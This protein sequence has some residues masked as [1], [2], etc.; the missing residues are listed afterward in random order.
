M[1]RKGSMVFILTL[2]L[3]ICFP[4]AIPINAPTRPI[5]VKS[6]EEGFLDNGSNIATQSVGE[7]RYENIIV[8]NISL[9]GKY[10]GPIRMVD[11]ANVSGGIDYVI[12]GDDYITFNRSSHAI[13]INYTI[14]DYAIGDLDMDGYDE[15]VVLTD[16][17]LYAV[18]DDSTL[19]WIAT[20]NGDVDRVYIGNITSPDYGLVICWKNNT[21][22][23]AYYNYTGEY[24]GGV[25]LNVT[26]ER[27]NIT[28][29]G[30]L[31]EYLV[32]RN[33]YDSCLY[34]WT[35]NATNATS[36]DPICVYSAFVRAGGAIYCVRYNKVID[37]A[38]LC[39]IRSATGGIS[40]TYTINNTD[41]WRGFVFSSREILLYDMDMDGFPEFVQHNGSMM[42]LV[43]VLEGSDY[44][45]RYE[46]VASF[47]DVSINDGYV[48][49]LYGGSVRL[50]EPL[51]DGLSI[52]GSLELV[53]PI[54]L[55]SPNSR[56]LCYGPYGE[57]YDVVMN[58]A[59]ETFIDAGWRYRIGDDHIVFY[60]AKR[61]VDIYPEEI[62]EYIFDGFID[63]AIPTTNG[64][65]VVWRGGSFS[66]YDRDRGLVW[67]EITDVKYPIA[68]DYDNE[69]DRVCV[70][71]GNGEIYVFSPSFNATYYTNITG[72]L[73]VSQVY[74][75]NGDFYI[76]IANVSSVGLT[77]R[78]LRGA[79]TY[80]R[81]DIEVLA[82]K[83][84]ASFSMEDIDSD[85]TYELAYF[86]VA[87]NNTGAHYMLVVRDD[88]EIYRTETDISSTNLTTRGLVASFWDSFVFLVPTGEFIRVFSDGLQEE[89]SDGAGVFASE[90]VLVFE[91]K[92]LFFTGNGMAWINAGGIK[93][94]TSRYG[95]WTKAICLSNNYTLYNFTVGIDREPP[96]IHIISP[97]EGQVIKCS[98]VNI[99]WNVTDDLGVESVLLRVDDGGWMDVTNRTDMVLTDLS[100]GNYSI[101]VIAIDVANRSVNATRSFTIDLSI[102]LV[103][104]CADNG[105]WINRS[106]TSISWTVYGAVGNITIY[107]NGTE[108]YFTDK[109][110][111]GSYNLTLHEGY[112]Q[113]RIMARGPY[114][115]VSNVIYVGVDMT[116]P[117]L[118]ILEPANNTVYE[119]NDSYVVVVLRINATDNIGIDRVVMTYGGHV[120]EI[121]QEA[122]L[123][124][125]PGDY[126]FKITA[127]DYAGNSNTKMLHLIVRSP[128]T[129][130]NNEGGGVGLALVL[131]IVAGICV[132]IIIVRRKFARS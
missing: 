81:E 29:M 118:T 123:I 19:M 48:L 16:H 112:W 54:G 109:N 92:I 100:E 71:L 64:F 37:A 4:P 21:N 33:S 36:I 44:A 6:F 128:T 30:H 2:I 53:N 83:Y 105:S 58:S 23:V 57:A 3:S 106:W 5:N 22:F 93:S 121:S 59:Y 62:D 82:N 61:V 124:L 70:V 79:S 8:S 113:I 73:L 68:G 56:V 12:I 98:S 67:G 117:I 74:F 101:C 69:S 95:R 122:N 104:F 40:K 110:L 76:M 66:V 26:V 31:G 90:G 111:N 87:I 84:T 86:I 72:E 27:L 13:Q 99:S 50:Y 15:V 126:M 94:C 9:V 91:D 107:L 125:S 28:Q 11:L 18:D 1:H 41:D 25:S 65:I 63:Y 115:S 119:T 127:Y 42:A 38:E 131:S 97:Y 102:G 46:A 85:G 45:L 120:V 80:I 129:T 49:T 20:R 77:F 52:M 89:Y 47:E 114:G 132:G 43:D 35:Y 130:K 39:E 24:L 32:A 10:P 51:N 103:V 17:L 60:Q 78:I 116:P 88:G 7:G 75:R 108:A 14:L 96:V 34:C 55:S